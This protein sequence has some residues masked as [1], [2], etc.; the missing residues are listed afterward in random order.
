MAPQ[1]SVICDVYDP[2]TEKV[3]PKDP[4]STAKQ[5]EEYLRKSGVADTSYWGPEIEFFV[6]DKISV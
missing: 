6:F 4:R 3:F 5:A 1:L 2:N